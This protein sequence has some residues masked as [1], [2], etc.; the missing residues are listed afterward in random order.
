VV[1]TDARLTASEC[2]LL[3]ESAH[4]GTDVVAA[5]VRSAVA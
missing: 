5:A 2:R 4:H 3:A 1:A